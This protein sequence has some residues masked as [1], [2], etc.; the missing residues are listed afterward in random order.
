MLGVLGAL[1]PAPVIVVETD[2]LPPDELLEEERR[3]IDTTRP[4]R[5]AEFLS[6]RVCARRALAALGIERFALLRDENRAPIWPTDVAGSLTHT[7]NY[8]AAAVARRADV[9]SLGI[10]VEQVGRLSEA[11]WSF[12]FTAEEQAMLQGLPG[13][14]R[15]ASA[16]TLFS[17][18]EA[19][20]KCRYQVRREP[21]GFHDV[22]IELSGEAFQVRATDAALRERRGHV[23]ASGCFEVRGDWVFVAVVAGA[24][25][26]PP[27]FDGALRSR[28]Q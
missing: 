15:M 8:T 6:G 7:A 23:P 14:R 26:S 11:R 13:D 2:S 28:L 22:E 12:V 10:D 4:G 19:Y 18:K 5:R 9:P 27:G 16:A 20:Y 17:A 25:E 1:L 21:L 3:L 24:P